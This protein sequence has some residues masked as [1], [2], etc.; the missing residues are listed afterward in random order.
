MGLARYAVIDVG[1]NSVKFHVARARRRRAVADHRRPGRDDASRRGPRATTA[2]ISTEPLER[3]VAA[4]AGMVE[5]ARRHGV[6]GDRRGR[7]RGLRIAR[8]ATTSSR[9]IRART[10]VTVEVISGEEESR[11]AYLAVQAGL[12]RR[13]RVPRRLRHRRRQH[14]SSPSATGPHVDERFSVKVGAV[15]YTERFG[16]TG[17][18]AP[19][20]AGRA[21]ARSPPTSSR[22]DGRPP[23]DALVGMGGA[24]TNI[25][26][27]KLGLATYDPDG[28]Q[29]SD[30]G[31]RPRSTARSSCTASRDAEASPRHR[32]PPAQARRRHPRRRMH[33]PHGH[34]QAGPGNADGE[35]PRPASR[36][37]DRAVRRLTPADRQGAG[38]R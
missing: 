38:P 12:G 34:G 3:T 23:P 13:P 19:E 11:L 17:A 4:I 14:R 37:A 7:H 31:P 25:T 6:R 9:P 27:V 1:T 20:R 8:N 35:R 29:G 5:E 21:L 33:R 16:L 36:P 32:R 18:V 28:V 15:R 22:L 30:P 24:I 26:A 2:A 10:G